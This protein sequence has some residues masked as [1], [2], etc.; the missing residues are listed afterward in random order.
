MISPSPPAEGGAGADRAGAAQQG[1]RPQ[2]QSGGRHVKIHVAVLFHKMNVTSRTAAA[3]AG[4][5][6]LAASPPQIQ[7]AA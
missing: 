4:A 6:L 7:A 2:A 3:V 5:R 1:D